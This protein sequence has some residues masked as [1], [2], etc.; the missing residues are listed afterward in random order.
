M[1]LIEVQNLSK[2]FGDIR[3][4]DG[5]NFSVKE[6]EIF[7]FLGPNGAGKTTTIRMLTGVIDP[8]SGHIKI[9]GQPFLKKE[10]KIK[11][12]IG[13]VP[14]MANVYVDLTGLENIL[15]IGELY[16]VPKAVRKER[17]IELLKKF[18]LYPRRD[19]K[20]K[21]YSKGMKQRLLL[22]M[23]LVSEPELLF[24]DEPTTGLDVKSSTIIKDLIREYNEKG[25]TIFLTT[26]DMH[27]ANDL[28]ERIAIMN[29]GKIVGLNTPENLKKIIQEE[30]VIEITFKEPVNEKEL[31][32]HLSYKSIE[33]VKKRW[34][35][36]VE[37]T[38]QSIINIT[39]FAKSNNLKIEKLQTT[40][41]HLEDVFLKIIEESNK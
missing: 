20:A 10:I 11:Q 38:H 21:K 41:P 7:G 17:A 29:Q 23:A 39:E 1:N 32:N 22:C 8:T 30:Q 27:V 37:D 5:I 18:E 34:R 28:C 16:G 24:L 3:A 26:H 25:T 19:Q 35:I 12:K 15:L 6:G 4:V 2:Y 31:R 36:V 14:E 9:F 33:S 13:N 40:E